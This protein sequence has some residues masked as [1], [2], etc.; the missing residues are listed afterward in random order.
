MRV[1]AVCAAVVIL[2]A[3]RNWVRKQ[4]VSWTGTEVGQVRGPRRPER[5]GA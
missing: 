1:I 5:F 4:L 3:G 2:I